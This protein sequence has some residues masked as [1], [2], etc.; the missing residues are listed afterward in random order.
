MRG[1]SGCDNARMRADGSRS[2][3]DP[4]GSILSIGSSGSIL[5][6]GSSGS[7][8]SIGSSGS[9]LSIGS[10]GSFASLLSVASFLS[11][12]SVLSGLSRWSLLSWRSA[13]AVRSAGRGGSGPPVRP[14]LSRAFRL[15]KTLQHGNGAVRRSDGR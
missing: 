4:T 15:Q 6:I 5:S 10:A 1:R 8:L 13:G 2:V 9:I 11:V 14:V 7:I 12:G 3:N